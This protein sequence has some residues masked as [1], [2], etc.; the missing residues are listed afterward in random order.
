[1]HSYDNLVREA[2]YHNIAQCAGSSNIYFFGRKKN[3]QAHNK[4]GRKQEK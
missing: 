1:M 4:Q 3:N 2:Q